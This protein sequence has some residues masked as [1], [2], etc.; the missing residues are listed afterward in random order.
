MMISP[1]FSDGM[2]RWRTKHKWNLFICFSRQDVTNVSNFGCDLRMSM[3]MHIFSKLTWFGY[4]IVFVISRS[5]MRWWHER[6]RRARIPIF[7][8]FGS[9]RYLHCI[10]SSIS[11]ILADWLR[12]CSLF[13]KIIRSYVIN[14]NIAGIWCCAAAA[15]LVDMRCVST[16]SWYVQIRYIDSV[17]RSM[18]LALSASCRI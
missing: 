5:G 16:S 15:M 17:S 14:L 6:V 2:R 18:G 13:K 12:L 11:C 1:H 8:I 10:F 7:S 9:W 4:L 3:E